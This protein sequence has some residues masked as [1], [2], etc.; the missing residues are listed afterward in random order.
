MTAVLFIWKITT[1]HWS[2]SHGPPLHEIKPFQKRM[3][4]KFRWVSSFGS[5]F[6]YDYHVSFT[7]EE[8]A[9]G[10]GYHNYEIVDLEIDEL[11]GTSVFYKDENGTVFHTYSSFGR[12]AEEL[13]NTYNFLDLTPKGRNETG[14]AQDLTDWV[15]HHDRYGVEEKEK[16]PCACSTQVPE[17]GKKR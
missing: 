17:T 14:P 8:M 11:P 9:K 16:A 7:P 3:G 6:N 15:R 5:D 10:K 4:W 1:F 13:T 2:R 12:G